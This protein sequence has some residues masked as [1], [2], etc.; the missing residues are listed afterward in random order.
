[1]PPREFCC[2]PLLHKEEK[3]SPAARPISSL[4]PTATCGESLFLRFKARK[5]SRAALTLLKKTNRNAEETWKSMS[6]AHCPT[7]QLPSFFQWTVGRQPILPS[8]RNLKSW[9]PIMLP[10]RASDCW[11]LLAHFIPS[12]ELRC[13]R[14]PALIQFILII[15]TRA[16]TKSHWNFRPASPSNPCL[17]PSP[18]IEKPGATKLEVNSEALRSTS[19]GPSDYLDSHFLRQ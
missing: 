10:A 19:G 12:L 4:T 3:P 6:S 9:L 1:M 5:L 17:R 18:S 2:R 15:L 8:K 13:H 11:F 16:T 7:G 14:R